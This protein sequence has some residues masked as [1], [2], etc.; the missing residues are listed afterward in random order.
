MAESIYIAQI[1][2]NI[3]SCTYYT[4]VCR[5]LLTTPTHLERFASTGLYIH[6]YTC[7]CSPGLSGD[8]MTVDLSHSSVFGPRARRGC[9]L[10]LQA[11][12]FTTHH[13][14]HS[15]SYFFSKFKWELCCRQSNE[16]IIPPGIRPFTK[17]KTNLSRKQ[18]RTC[19][20]AEP[21]HS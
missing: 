9:L 14:T 4:L 15:G 12:L 18:L 11:K 16:G 1:E 6:V 7:T 10:C 5:L 8:G 3:N 13:S 19:S 21:R 17:E 20:Q 2:R